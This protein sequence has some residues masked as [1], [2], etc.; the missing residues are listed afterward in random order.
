[1]EIYFVEIPKFKL[2]DIRKMKAFETRIM[3]KVMNVER[4]F[5]MDKMQRRE[6]KQKK[7]L[8]IITLIQMKVMKVEYSKKNKI[9]QRKEI[10][11]N[12]LTLGVSMEM[13]I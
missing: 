2:K 6:Y 3:K 8:E 4:S 1:M 12:I 9:N 7:S 11:L 5:L 10:A 13:I